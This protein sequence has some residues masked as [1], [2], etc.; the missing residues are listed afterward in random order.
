MD[1]LDRYLIRE[2]VIYFVLILFGFGILFIAIDF[3]SHFWNMN[4][5]VD[6]II[7]IYAYMLPGALQQ[8]VPVAAL[9]STLLVLSMMSKQNEILALYSGGVGNLR[10]ISTFIATIAALST[11]AFLIFDPIVPLFEKRRDFIRRGMD[12]DKEE[13]IN[14]RQGHFWYRSGGIIYNVG[15]FNPE[16][17]TLEG[18]NIFLLTPD[19]AISEKFRAKNAVFDEN[20]WTVNAGFSVKYPESNFPMAELF[21]KKVGLIPEKPSDY[22]TLQVKED[23]MRLK[24]LRRYISRN[25]SYG[26]DTT[27]QQ[28]HYHE[29]IA[30]IFTPLILV[31]L[32]IA[33][34]M[35]PLKTQSAASSVGFCFM[36][37]FAYL[38]LFRMT[39]S[40]GRGGFIPATIAGWTPNIIFLGIS[41]WL[42]YRRRHY[43]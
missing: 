25:R 11:I 22:R 28:V 20:Q 40:V 1:T 26:L 10:V 16:K 13:A 23:T 39:V 31:L 4:Q 30:L 9:M 21:E 34:S 2:L 3:L 8:F 18:L 33:F 14:L 32:G 19:F 41:I 36:V 15:G 29:R 38:L 7:K 35:K 27:G 12:P 37:V 6:R 43:A 17:N 42:L 5:P 24:E